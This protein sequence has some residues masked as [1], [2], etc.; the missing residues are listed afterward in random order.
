[1]RRRRYQ[2][3][4]RQMM[5]LVLLGVIWV[6]IKLSWRDYTQRVRSEQAIQALALTMRRVPVYLFPEAAD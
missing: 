4:I 6:Q 1:M 3:S 5:L 2:L